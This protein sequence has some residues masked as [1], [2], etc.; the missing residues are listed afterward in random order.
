MGL[1]D[2]IKRGLSRTRENVG[3]RMD[4]L[5]ELHE[6]LTEEFYEDLTD[7]LIM[8]D[9][10]VKTAQLVVDRLRERCEAEK[11]P[12]TQKARQAL[13]DI[14]V[15]LMGSEP[16]SSLRHGAIGDWREWRGQNHVHWQAG[17]APAYGGAQRDHLRRGYVSRGGGG[18]AHRVGGAR[19]CA[20]CEAGGRGGSRRRG[21]R[22][23]AGRQEPLR[24]CVDCGYRGRLHNKTH[25]MEELKKISRVVSREYPEAAVKALLVLDATTGQNGLQ[26]AM[27]FR[28][29]ANIDGLILTKLDGTAKGGIAIAIRQEL[30]LPVRYIGVGEQID[31]LQPFNA[32]EFID[33]IF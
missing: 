12:N 28:D 14:L 3:A 20:D 18:S 25:L 16:M 27:V 13:K 10:G 30:G 15:D 8:A 1:F 31:D 4:E 22:W 6:D 26:Q 32:R 19:G 29:V 24:R 17:R 11:I 9:V 21:V 33:A 2:R 5:V 23:R 7:I